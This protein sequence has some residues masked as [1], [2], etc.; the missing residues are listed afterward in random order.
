MWQVY[1]DGCL[2]D[3]FCFVVSCLVPF[4]FCLICFEFLFYCVI[5]IGILYSSIY[6][7]PLSL[8]AL[9]LQSFQML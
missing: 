7:G 9:Y 6:F 4:C 3:L 5:A 8:F 2:F 1:I